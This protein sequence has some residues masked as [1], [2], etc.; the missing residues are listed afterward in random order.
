MA[1]QENY[2]PINAFYITCLRDKRSKNRPPATWAD[3]K[4]GEIKE[5]RTKLNSVDL[6][7]YMMLLSRADKN[8]ECYPSIETIC[9]DCGGLDRRLVWKH[10][11]QLEQMRMI[12]IEKSKGRPNKYYMCDFAEWL[13]EPSY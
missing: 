13:K 10:L 6:L 2:L 7:I 9:E 3:K 4:T 1:K 11:Q 12:S 5:I 8:L